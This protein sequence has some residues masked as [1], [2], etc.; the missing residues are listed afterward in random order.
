MQELGV[1]KGLPFIAHTGMWSDVTLFAA[2]MATIL[3]MYASQWKIWQWGLALTI[4]FVCSAAMHWGL[5][6]RGPFPEAHV[7]DGLVTSAGMVHFI[8]MAVGI[9]M[10]IL[11]YTCTANL[12]P[13]IVTSVS[14][15]IVIH[16][17]IGTL[18]PLKIWANVAHPIWYPDQPVL[19]MPT[20]ITM[21]G[22]AAILWWASRWAV[23]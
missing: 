2:L 17:V 8:Y 21:L 6:V 22:V 18:I 23:R 14:V 5:Y 15:L 1:S 7:R 13:A 4:G 10:V 16:V 12:A 11:F 20:I 19:D 9:T 3:S